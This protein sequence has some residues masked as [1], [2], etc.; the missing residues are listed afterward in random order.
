MSTVSPLA[1]LT[2]ALP[3]TLTLTLTPTPTPTLARPQE[4]IPFAFAFEKTSLGAGFGDGPATLDVAPLSG[5]VGPGAELPIEFS[6]GP[7]IEKLFN[8]NVELRVKNKPTPLAVN[9]KG[10]GY[11]IHDTLQLEDAAGRPVEIS[12][13]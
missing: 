5:V 4:H 9:V 10:E 1:T 2:L 6:F 13:R 12:A 7:S 8:F 11:S 3:L